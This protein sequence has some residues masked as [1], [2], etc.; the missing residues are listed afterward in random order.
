M[1]DLIKDN[2]RLLHA[3][4]LVLAVTVLTGCSHSPLKA[5]CAALAAVAPAVADGP[6]EAKPVNR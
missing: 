6:C 1:P 5:P 4:A 2:F 3:A